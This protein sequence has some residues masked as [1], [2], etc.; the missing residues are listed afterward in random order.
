MLRRLDGHQI[1]H[2]HQITHQIYLTISEI[3]IIIFKK[4]KYLLFFYIFFFF[5]FCWCNTKY[6]CRLHWS[7]RRHR[8]DSRW[9][10][11]QKLYNKYIHSYSAWMIDMKEQVT[12]QRGSNSSVLTSRPIGTKDQSSFISWKHG[13]GSST[14]DCFIKY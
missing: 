3:V 14:K 5:N 7:E 2:H 10:F 12:E 8:L 6:N 11:V 13:T 1:T 9:N 4:S